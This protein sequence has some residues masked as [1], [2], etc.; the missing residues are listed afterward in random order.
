MKGKNWRI[1]LLIAIVTSAVTMALSSTTGG[2]V[3]NDYFADRK[4]VV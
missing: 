1:L 3:V 4:S 2:M